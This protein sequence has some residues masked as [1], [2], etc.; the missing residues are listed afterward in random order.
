MATQKVNP[1]LALLVAAVA[2]IVFVVGCGG[3]SSSSSSTPGSSTEDPSS[4]AS[5]AFLQPKSPNNKYVIFGSEASAAQRKV[6]SNVLGESLKAREKPDFAAQCATLNAATI[7]EVVE[8]KK[9]TAKTIAAPETC[10]DALK[11]L[12]EPF[13]DTEIA[14][15]DTLAGPISALRIKGAKAYALFHGTDKKDYA[16]PMEQ[17]D[18]QWKVGALLAI[19]LG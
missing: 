5:A 1:Q 12:A 2:L 11:K 15:I 3:G 10:P 6:A 9:K 18:G 17:E 14:R 16:M 7:K 19:S 4:E 13:P 8:P